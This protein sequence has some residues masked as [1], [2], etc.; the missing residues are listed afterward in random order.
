MSEDV[1]KNVQVLRGI[2]VNEFMGTMGFFAASL[3]MNCIDCH[4]KESAGNWDRY[5]DDT[6]LKQTAR[7][8]VL[9]EELINRADFGNIRMVTCYTCHRGYQNPGDDA[10]PAR[11]IRPSASDR[12]GSGAEDAGRRC[13]FRHRRANHRQIYSSHRRRAAT[14]QDNELHRKRDVY[15]V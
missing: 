4:A 11:P 10:Q 8:M 3:N 13:R 5:A 7:R 14:G 12:S 2:P 15:R 1:F 6:P 9:M